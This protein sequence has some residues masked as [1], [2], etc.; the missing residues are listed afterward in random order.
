MEYS[1]LNYWICGLFISLGVLGSRNTFRKLHLF[2]SSGEE[3]G[4]GGVEDTYSV[5]FT[6]PPVIEISSFILRGRTE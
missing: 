1:T 6:G 2:P 4:G 3:R 5:G